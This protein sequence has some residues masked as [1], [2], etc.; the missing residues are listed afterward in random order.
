MEQGTSSDENEMSDK[1]KRQCKS[2][3]RKDSYSDS[4]MSGEDDF[5]R[6]PAKMPS[7]AL[8]S[9]SN[10]TLTNMVSQTH[11]QCEAT[12]SQ[13]E[14]TCTMFYYPLKIPSEPEF[15]SRYCPCHTE[16][17]EQPVLLAAVYCF[18]N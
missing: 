8:T 6:T 10:Q 15:K 14:P 12:K 9:A 13:E 16:C 5:V 7:T 18:K 3:S 17:S 11:S 4:S 1:N 2:P